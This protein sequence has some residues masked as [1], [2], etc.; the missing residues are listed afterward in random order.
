MAQQA[1]PGAGEP[2]RDWERALLTGSAGDDAA[3]DGGGDAAGVREPR[4][5][6]PSP[7]ELAAEPPSSN[8]E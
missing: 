6:L 8:Q 4:R 7:D 2:L 5:P 1:A 3:D